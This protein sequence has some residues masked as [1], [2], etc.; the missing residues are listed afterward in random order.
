MKLIVDRREG[1]R[2]TWRGFTA[3]G[4]EVIKSFDQ[5]QLFWGGNPKFIIVATQYMQ[6]GYALGLSVIFTFWR[7]LHSEL[8]AF[9]PE[10]LLLFLLVSYTFFLHLAVEILPW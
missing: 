3:L 7:D 2:N 5:R 4:S 1:T 9:N 10:L 6:F 8:A